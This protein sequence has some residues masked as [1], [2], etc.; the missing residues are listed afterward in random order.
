MQQA[1]KFA[2]HLSFVRLKRKKTA[3]QG[4]SVLIFILL[5]HKVLLALIIQ[6]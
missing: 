3:Y 6:L 5:V 1:S 4:C 2:M